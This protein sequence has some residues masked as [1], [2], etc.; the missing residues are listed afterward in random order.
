MTVAN[1]VYAPSDDVLGN[2]KEMIRS[3]FQSNVVQL[4]GPNAALQINNWVDEQTNHTIKNIVSPRRCLLTFNESNLLLIIFFYDFAEDISA[5][6]ILL[7]NAIYFQA[8][9]HNPFHQASTELKPFYQNKFSVKR[10][11]TMKLITKNLYTGV[12]QD[13]DAKFVVLPYE[14]IR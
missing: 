7:I 5:N 13:L 6:A 11:P 3:M 14:V 12:I 8:Q 10:V 2:F 9:W 4:D 1:T